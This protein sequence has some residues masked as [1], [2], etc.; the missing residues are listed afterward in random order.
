M[1][2][3]MKIIHVSHFVASGCVNVAAGHFHFLPV[4]RTVV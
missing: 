1:V 3:G 4:K 2:V